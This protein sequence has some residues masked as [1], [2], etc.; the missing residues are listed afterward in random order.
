VAGLPRG[1]LLPQAGLNAV[2]LSCSQERGL[3]QPQAPESYYNVIRGDKEHVINIVVHLVE[4]LATAS[5]PIQACVEHFEKR[6]VQDAV[7]ST[8]GRLHHVSTTHIALKS[9]R[10]SHTCGS[11]PG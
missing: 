11:T 5:A 6:C 2:L 4:G 8:A 7:N 10:H 9:S 3:P 1:L